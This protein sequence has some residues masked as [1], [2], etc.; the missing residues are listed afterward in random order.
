MSPV[1]SCS[2]TVNVDFDSVTPAV[3]SSVMVTVASVVPLGVTPV[4][5]ASKP[6]FTDSPSSSTVSS[7]A[8]N[9]NGC[10]VLPLLKVTLSGVTE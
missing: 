10:E 7:A 4:G 1:A 2:V 5:R 8:V 6:S 9:V 3:S